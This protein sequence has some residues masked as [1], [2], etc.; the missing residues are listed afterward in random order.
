MSPDF[1]A[2]SRRHAAG[3]DSAADLGGAA[4]FASPGGFGAAAFAAAANFRHCGYIL[5]AA[6]VYFGSFGRLYEVF[7]KYSFWLMPN[8]GVR[9]V[10]NPPK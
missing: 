2:Y 8:N 5:L 7:E 9:R 6:N 1:M 4:G 10:S 3:L